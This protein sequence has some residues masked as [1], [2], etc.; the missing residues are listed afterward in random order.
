MGLAARRARPSKHNTHTYKATAVSTGMA[1]APSA[2]QKLGGTD[3]PIEARAS[4]RSPGSLLH[5]GTRTGSRTKEAAG[6]HT[7]GS[8]GESVLGRM[9]LVLGV[10]Q[11][12]M[13]R[14]WSKNGRS[15]SATFHHIHTHICISRSA[16]SWVRRDLLVHTSPPLGNLEVKQAM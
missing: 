5:N 1:T 7:R 16:E 3:L 8:R 12:K 14:N 4:D 13:R 11:R 10:Q 15:V 6:R 2:G 9:S